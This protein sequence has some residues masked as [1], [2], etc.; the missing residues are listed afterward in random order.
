LSLQSQNCYQIRDALIEDK[1][2]L[3]VFYSVGN[4]DALELHE[5]HHEPL[6]LVASPLLKGMDFRRESQHIDLGFISNGPMCLFRQT[7]ENTLQERN[8]TIDNMIEL[9]S[10]NTI[11]KCVESNIGITYLPRFTVQK[12]LEEGSLQELSFT[13]T[14]QMIRPLCGYHAGKC[15]TPAMKVFIECMKAAT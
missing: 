2:D 13:D 4:D 10:I 5:F 3:G 9:S 11:K 1:A 12:E 6:V 7:F 15:L 14:P 8:I